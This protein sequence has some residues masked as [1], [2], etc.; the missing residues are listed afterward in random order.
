MNGGVVVAFG[1][2]LGRSGGRNAAPN[3]CDAVLIGATYTL[4]GRDLVRNGECMLDSIT[5]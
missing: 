1:A 2:N 5:A 3:H 4:D